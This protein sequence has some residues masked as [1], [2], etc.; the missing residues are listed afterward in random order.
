MKIQNKILSIQIA[1]LIF[2]AIIIVILSSLCGLY[3]KNNVRNNAY[4]E[5]TIQEYIMLEKE[6]KDLQ[7]DYDKLLSDR[8]ELVEKIIDLEIDNTRLETEN[9]ILIRRLDK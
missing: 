7:D 2:A 3:Y 6:F 5:A 1:R 4:L 9:G 8:V